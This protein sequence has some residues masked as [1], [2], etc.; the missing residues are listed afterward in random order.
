[1]PPLREPGK[2][3]ARRPPVVT[4]SVIALCFLVFLTG[5][6]S[7]LGGTDGGGGPAL[8]AQVRYFDHWGV[9]PTELWHGPLA[10][11]A[12]GLP[13]GCHSPHYADKAPFVSVLTALFLHGNWLHLLG[14]M[15]FLFVFGAGV[16]RRMGPLRFALF[17]LAAG[18]AATYGYAVAHA[19]STQ[20][21]VGASGAIAGVLG[22]YLFLFPRA[23]VTS[24]LPFLLFLPLRFPAWLALGFWFVLQ[25]LAARAD[26][27]G[28]G[29]AY[30][31]HVIGF[32]FGFLCAG[33]CFRERSKLTPQAA[34]RGEG[35]P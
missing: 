2:T 8:C 22:G 7:G 3:A 26:T 5:P 1:M 16:E 29:V 33:A 30:L 17:Y 31:A 14:N 4:Y 9:I 13:Y 19:D 23:R 11:G 10:P 27:P 34:T 32:G 20:T 24:L 12:L 25:W 35:Q 21:L 6:A 15:L 28:P 18:Y